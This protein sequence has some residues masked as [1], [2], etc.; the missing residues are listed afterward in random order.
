MES[1][2]AYWNGIMKMSVFDLHL[3]ARA[4]NRFRDKGIWTV[5]DLVQYSVHDLM[6]IK[7]FGRVTLDEVVQA[8]DELNLTL[9]K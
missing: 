4:Y 3:S 1:N 6:R 9:K 7:G 5:G 2:R 8:L